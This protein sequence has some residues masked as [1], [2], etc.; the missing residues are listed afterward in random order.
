MV[1]R[2]HQTKIIVGPG[3]ITKP[4]EKRDIYGYIMYVVVFLLI[5][6]M[7]LYKISPIYIMYY[8]AN[9]DIIANILTTIKHPNFFGNIYLGDPDTLIQYISVISINYVALISL[10]YV[11]ICLHERVPT[12]KALSVA[13]VMTLVTF[14]IPTY[15]VPI[16]IKK[17]ERWLEPKQISERTKLIISYV[18]GILGGLGFIFVEKEIIE[19]FI[20]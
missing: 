6:P 5:L 12:M 20:L 16:L 19:W 18:T 8:M 13:A 4:S 2:L 15:V 10:F 14:L 17:M 9:V 1:S 11:V 3:P 7:T